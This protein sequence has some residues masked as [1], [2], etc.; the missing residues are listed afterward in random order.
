ML[1]LQVEKLEILFD[2]FNEKLFGD[3]FQTRPVIT[4]QSSG[5]RRSLGWCTVG[6]IWEEDGGSTFHEINISAEHLGSGIE[7]V[8]ATLLHEMCHLYNLFETGVA[9]TNAKTQ[10]HSLAFK[11]VAEGVGLI[12]EKVGRYG[13]AH[14]SLSDKLR[15]LIKKSEIQDVFNIRRMNMTSTTPTKKR[16]P[17]PTTS[18]PG[19]DPNMDAYALICPKCQNA[20][21]TFNA[22]G[23]YCS[24]CSVAYELKE[25]Y[26][27]KKSV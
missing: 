6:K 27:C 14:T 5:R 1:E 12:V 7:P 16:K 21:I 11:R 10:Y 8:A 15:D 23:V 17:K 25:V 22:D 26:K 20:V 13:Y 19:V 4:I 2:Y 18:I 24:K 9:D 3:Y